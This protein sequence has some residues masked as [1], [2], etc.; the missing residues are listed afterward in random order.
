M[1][2]KAAGETIRTSIR[3]RPC[4]LK[5]KEA[6]PGPSLVQAADG[7]VRVYQRPASP[8]GTSSSSSPQPSRRCDAWLRWTLAAKLESQFG[9][10]LHPFDVRLQHTWWHGSMLVCCTIRSTVHYLCLRWSFCSSSRQH[11]AVHNS[12]ISPAIAPYADQDCQLCTCCMQQFAS[13]GF[14]TTSDSHRH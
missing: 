4:S 3:I 7:E 8:T 10:P 6:Y 11:V 5:E 13:N 9:K 2:Q 12:H 14:E 1:S